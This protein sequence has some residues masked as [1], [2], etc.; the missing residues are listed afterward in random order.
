MPT[1]EI[2]IEKLEHHLVAACSSPAVQC[3]FLSPFPQGSLFS[4]Q[5]FNFCFDEFICIL[6]LFLF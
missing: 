1:I 6:T 5:Y 3:V 4:D 2:M